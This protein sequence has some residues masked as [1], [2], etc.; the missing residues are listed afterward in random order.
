MMKKSKATA[1]FRKRVS[2]S[3]C[4]SY[5]DEVAVSRVGNVVVIQH[6]IIRRVAAVE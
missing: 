6:L 1:G 2:A 5:Y 3:L 4:V